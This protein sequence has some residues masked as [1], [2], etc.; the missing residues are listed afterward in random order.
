[1]FNVQARRA[2]I[3]ATIAA[4]TLAAFPGQAAVYSN[5]NKPATFDVTMGI[6][7]DCTIS[8]A[9]MNFGAAR[10]VLAT[11]VNATSNITVTCTNTTPFNL[12]LDQGTGTGSSGTDRYLTGTGASPASVKFNLLQASGGAQWGNTQGTDTLG[13]TG[14]G[15]QQTLTVYGEIPAQASPRPDTYKSTITATV[16]F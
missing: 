2:L 10:G 7:A 1:M 8:A 5:G 3:A 9:A 4:T 16:Y 14:T 12:G 13:G 15:V 11:A 6:I